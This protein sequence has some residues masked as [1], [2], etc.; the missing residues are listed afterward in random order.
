ML[1]SFNQDELNDLEIHI[2]QKKTAVK[3]LASIRNEKNLLQ[4]STPIP[5]E[6]FKDLKTHI[7]LTYYQNYV[8][9]LLIPMGVTR[10]RSTWTA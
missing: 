6:I 8:S 4:P 5:E 7:D 9:G 10:T 2:F 3:W 1:Q